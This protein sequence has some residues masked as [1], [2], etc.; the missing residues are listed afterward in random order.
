MADLY[1]SQNSLV[2]VTLTGEKR[3][4]LVVKQQST[5]YHLL[6]ASKNIKNHSSI[7][8]SRIVT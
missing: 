3:K 4:N 8:T 7:R 5:F 2:S 1:L 6:E